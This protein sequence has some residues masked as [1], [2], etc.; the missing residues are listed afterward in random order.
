MINTIRAGDVIRLPSRNTVMVIA[1][2]K[3]QEWVC[4]FTQHSKARG[5]VIFTAAFLQAFGVR[6]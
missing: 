6:A 2:L 4:V 1:R 3:G 5:E